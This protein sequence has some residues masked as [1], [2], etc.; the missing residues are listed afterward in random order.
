V[1]QR[2]TKNLKMGQDGRQDESQIHTQRLPNQLVPENA[3]F[4]T[5]GVDSEGIH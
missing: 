3:E 5:E 1:L 2:K 4:E